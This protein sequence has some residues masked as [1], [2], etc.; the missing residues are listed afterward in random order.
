[1]EPT[2]NY[3]PPDAPPPANRFDASPAPAAETGVY[4]PDGNTPSGATY[5]AGNPAGDPAGDPADNQAGD[6]PPTIPPTEEPP[7][8]PRPVIKSNSL[9]RDIR[10]TVLMVV[11]IYTLVNLIAPRYIVEGASMQPNFET[12]EW[13]IVNRL[14]YLIG[15]PQRGDVVIID[16][17]EPQEDLIKRVIGL[18]GET[19]EI[20]DGVVY[21]DGA[22]LPEHY[23]NAQPR[24]DGEW[25]LGPEEY[26]VLGDNRNNS[27][28]SHSFGALN[29]EQIVGRAW[30][31]YWP[32]E[33]WGVV[34]GQS[35]DDQTPLPSFTPRATRLP[36]TPYN[37]PNFRGTPTPAMPDIVFATPTPFAM[38]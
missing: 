4:P 14:P 1:M 29:R 3:P 24:Y 23:I 28:D 18:P 36:N 35:Y 5:P 13:I 15:E 2:S 17:A 9:L 38:P 6:T 31:I 8:L 21:I 25:T 22:A 34:P 11:A 12:G 37:G 30:I 32:P 16:F 33:Q 19:V 7:A 27:R 10:D 20:H 26:F